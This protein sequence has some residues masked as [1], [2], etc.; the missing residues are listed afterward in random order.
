MDF[1]EA[2]KNS[3]YML[4]RN[5]MRSFLTMLGIVIGVMSVIVVISLGNSAQGL[6]LNEVKSLGSNLIGVL[7]GKSD[8]NGPP[9]SVFGIVITTLKYRDGTEIL[10]NNNPHIE[11]VAMYVQGT[12]IASWNGNNKVKTFMG[13]TASYIN[14][15]DAKID[16]GRFFTAEEELSN[17]KV[18]VIG[19]E[20]VSDLFGDQNPIGEKI[21]IKKTNFTVIGVF[22]KR[23]GGLIQNQDKEIFIP[24]KTAQNVLLG[25]EHISFMRIK[26]DKTENIDGVVTYVK[27]VLRKD[28]NIQDAVDDDFSVRSST[29][30]LE[31]ISQITNAIKF[32]L[33]AISAISLLVGGFGIMNIMLATVQERTKEIGLRKAVGAKNRDIILQF[34]IETVFI[35]FVSGIIGIILGVLISVVVAVVAVALGY[36][37]PLIISP[38]SIFLGSFV[39][40]SVGLIFGITPARTASLLDPIEALRH[41]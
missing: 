14:V 38:W 25:I 12:D 34:L 1:N 15:E 16:Q 31:S 20:V 36:N 33:V 21:K 7:P 39:S 27:E 29:T 6:I 26:V 24:I 23:G 10:R 32:F 18:A 28:H 30:S 11:G 17:A 8:S 40:I 3:F 37:W 35:T 4:V 13:T 5:K 9:A 19:S 2:V 22:T 41:E